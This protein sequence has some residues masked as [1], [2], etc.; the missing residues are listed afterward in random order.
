MSIL[1][2]AAC[3][4]VNDFPLFPLFHQLHVLHAVR[5]AELPNSSRPN[6]I[7]FISARCFLRASNHECLAW[8]KP[9]QQ[10]RRLQQG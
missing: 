10:L 8:S 7:A 4:A 2:S 3:D 9:W 1:S 5:P 6:C